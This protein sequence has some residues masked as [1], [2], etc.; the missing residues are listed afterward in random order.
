MATKITMPLMG[1]SVTDA[2]I[3]RWLKKIGDP[4][5]EFEPV[6]EVTTDKVDSEITAEAAGVLLA[7]AAQEGAVIPV[8][9]L[10]GWIGQPGEA[11]PSGDTPQP[12]P[13]AAPPPPATPAA[14]PAAPPATHGPTNGVTNGS[15][16]HNAPIATPQPAPMA[17][18]TAEHTSNDLGFISPVVARLAAEHNVDLR[19][20]PGSGR[21]GRITK[22]D[23]LAYVEQR[24][25]EI[26]RPAAPMTVPAPPAP[27]PTPSD[28]PTTPAPT[29][30][31]ADDSI[32]IPLTAMRRAIAEHMVR[33]KH[34][35]PHATTVFEVDMLAVSR[36]RA[37]HKA[38]YESRG[39]N[40]T[41]TAYFVFAAAQALRA[42]PMVNSSFGDTHV[43]QHRHVHIGLAVS[44]G[45]AGL[46]VPVIRNADEL[47]LQGV[48]RAVNDVAYRARNKQIKPDELTGGTFSI[49]NH[50]TSGSIFATPVINQPQAAI[51][52]IGAIEKRVKVIDDAIAIRPLT[53][54]SLSFDHRLLDGNAADNFVAHIKR[55][56]ESWQ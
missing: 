55:T 22:T 47:N 31:T 40:L 33:S 28:A 42:F 12:A 11:I 27:R 18:A 52:G 15:A 44:L 4:V 48:A 16:Q 45:D 7:I 49:T 39:V 37:A 20:V 21:G 35:S 2:T 3:S 38:D 41:F 36:H 14:P 17:A 24:G 54:L 8:G 29:I 23:V 43:L 51:L 5:E 1:E 50:G 26:T 9:G 56:L 13:A 19:R 10:L 6:L 30:P 53:Y 46:M 32:A 25:A 34:T